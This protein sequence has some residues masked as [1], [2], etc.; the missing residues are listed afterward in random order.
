MACSI[1]FILWKNDKFKPLRLKEEIMG[2]LYQNQ[3]E[4]IGN[5]PVVKVKSLSNLTGCNI[6]VKCEYMNPGGSIKDRAAKQIV[7]DALAEKKIAT[8]N[9]GS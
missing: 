6:F 8:R 3:L 4:L 5:T 1:I 2:K 7:L 9:D